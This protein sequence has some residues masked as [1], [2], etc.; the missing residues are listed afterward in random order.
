MVRQRLNKQWAGVSVSSATLREEDLIPAFE[1]TLAE[2]DITPERPES[3]NKL[4]NTDDDLTDDER[5]EVALY[6]NETLF[7]ALQ[8]IAPRGCYFGAHPGDGA[9]F[10]FWSVDDE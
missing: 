8:N 1:E 10:G 5:E 7:D 6:L 9:D 2:L 4:L 3:V